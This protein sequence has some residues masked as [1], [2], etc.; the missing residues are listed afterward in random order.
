[1]TAAAHRGAASKASQPLA[2]RLL[3][4]EGVPILLVL[5]AI[6]VALM[7][8]APNAFLGWRT[9]VSVMINYQPQIIC[10]L[11]A[12]SNAGKIAPIASPI[13]RSKPFAAG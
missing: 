1:M 9:Y 11:V 12:T 7:I 4:T 6:L 10:V 5:I 13:A 3:A 8:L 2:A